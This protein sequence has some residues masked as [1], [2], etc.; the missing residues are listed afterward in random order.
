MDP[1]F[2][3]HSIAD[4]TTRFGGYLVIILALSTAIH[5]GVR[6]I[7]GLLGV[8]LEGVADEFVIGVLGILFALMLDLNLF[9]YV[10][11]I[12][13]TQLVLSQ[14]ARL[15]DGSPSGIF[16]PVMV[17]GLSNIVTGTMVVGGRKVIVG[18]AKEFGAGVEGIK[19]ALNKNNKD[20]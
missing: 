12:T 8:D 9:F 6:G 19:K 4:I 2:V 13:N 11:G 15:A 7:L 20:S 5:G 17:I 14:A 16:P 1:N 18:I 3:Q 10:I